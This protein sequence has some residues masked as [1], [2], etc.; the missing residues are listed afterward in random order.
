MGAI[1][2]GAHLFPSAPAK[3]KAQLPGAAIAAAKGP[4]EQEKQNGPFQHA[5]PA[6]TRDILAPAQRAPPG[7]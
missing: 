1:G 3:E 4:Q 7:S 6:G 2:G 5:M